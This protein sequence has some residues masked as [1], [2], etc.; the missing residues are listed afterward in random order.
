MLSSTSN[1]I[2]G[3]IEEVEIG[4]LSHSPGFY[5][6]V[7]SGLQDLSRSI[8][9]KGLLHPITVRAK[10]GEQQHFEIVAGNRRFLACKALGWR[11]ILCHVVELN[12]REAFEISLVENIQRRTLNPVEEAYAFKAY[13]SDFGWG[14]VTDLATK[15]GKSVSYVDRRLGLLRL[16]DNILQRILSSSLDISAANELIPI[17]KK[18]EQSKLADLI[19]KRC[20]SIKQV[21]ELRKNNEENSVYDDHGGTMTLSE[22]IS[23]LDKKAQKCLDKSITAIKIAMSKIADIMESVE[24]NW[25]IYETLMQHRIAL[26]AQVDILIKE[27]KKL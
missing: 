1:L 25:I 13:I 4:E 11:K 15:I 23:A 20:L 9:E 27:K 24:D 10:E 3:I 18:N 21:R 12:D 16:P 2:L 5:P 7:A 17:H 19:S 26:H 14:G 22:D 6:S 8:G